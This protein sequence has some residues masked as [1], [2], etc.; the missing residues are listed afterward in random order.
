M[1][2]LLFFV[3]LF[4]FA[5]CKSISSQYSQKTINDRKVCFYLNIENNAQ[6]IFIR[7][8]KES[9]NVVDFENCDYLVLTTLYQVQS[10]IMNPMGIRVESRIA[11]NLVYDIYKND[12]TK[13][14]QI[15]SIL[16]N[17]ILQKYDQYTGSKGGSMSKG[18]GVSVNE[19]QEK[20]YEIKSSYNVYTGTKIRIDNLLAKV[21]Q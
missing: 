13:I 5:G 10:D 11:M 8:I 2:N 12:K 18:S 7:R 1:K 15:K 19:H 3:T 4:I 21:S 9:P 17:P 20:N 16:D 14:M 6:R